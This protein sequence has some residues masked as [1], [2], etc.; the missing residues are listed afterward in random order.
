MLKVDWVARAHA[1]KPQ[2]L[3]CV[4]GRFTAPGGGDLVRKSSPRDGSLLCEFGAGHAQE[5]DE[6]VAACRRAFED[7]RWSRLPMERRKSVLYRFADL[8]ERHHDELALLE[9]LDVGKPISDAFDF[10]I[11]ASAAKIRYAAEAIDKLSGKVYAVEQTS[12]SYELRRPVGVVAGIVGWNFPLLLAVNKIGPALA[13]GNSLVLKPSELTSLSA[14]QVAELALEAG[15]PEGVF[16]VIHGGPAVGAMLARHP[17]V[18][19]L[20]FTGSSQ[21][22]RKLLVS[23]GESNMKRLILE[24]GGKAPNIVFDD[25]PDLEGVSDAIVRRAF[26]NQGEVCSASSRL[27]VHE[28]V[29]DEL[30]RLVIRKSAALGMGDPLEPSTR[31]GAVVSREHRDKVLR[32]IECGEREG[33]RAAYRSQAVAPLRDGFYVA[34]V[35]FDDVSPP[36]RIAQEEIFGPVLSVI[37]FRDEEDA[38]RIANGTIYGLSAILWTRDVGRAHRVS[39]GVNAGWIVVNATACPAGGGEAALP[40]GGH[41]Q[42]GIG[43]EGGLEGMEAYLSR[44]AVQVFV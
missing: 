5:V 34:P 21:T 8:I 23:A 20:T 42:S 18:D 6:A 2:V 26:W 25:C 16:N 17:D 37:T 43:A 15:L 12:L 14:G 33:A 22:G 10:D 36:H 1:L 39:R 27:L 32:Y 13:A 30:M 3:N 44:S 7:G 41:R 19:L 31:F 11:P 29:K 40:I 38:I 28:G 4:N 9:S 24:C 35:I